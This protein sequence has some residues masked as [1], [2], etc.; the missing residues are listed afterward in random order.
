MT[1]RRLRIGAMIAIALAIV[2]FVTG[3]DV[4]RWISVALVLASIPVLT[5]TLMHPPRRDA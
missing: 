1:R 3:V 4:L 5:W 2:L